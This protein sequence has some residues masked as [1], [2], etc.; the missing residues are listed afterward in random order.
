[1]RSFTVLFAIAALS[2]A[3]VGIAGPT[4]PSKF[5]GSRYSGQKALYDFNLEN[6]EDI[7]GAL[8]YV[9]NHLK[10]IKEFGDPKSSRIV[11]VAHGNEIHALSRLN[12]AAYPEMYDQLKALESDWIDVDGVCGEK[13]K[14]AAA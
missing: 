2:I 8:G 4:D 11:I 7:A 12:R 6:P 13:G 1:M 5:D 3:A 10:A 9:R 14:V